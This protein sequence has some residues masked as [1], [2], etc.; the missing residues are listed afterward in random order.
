M[1]E[2]LLQRSSS[3]I[4]LV[5]WLKA[6]QSSLLGDLM[7]AQDS[8][9]ATGVMKRLGVLLGEMS[10]V[11]S[12]PSRIE[13]TSGHSFFRTISGRIT[14]R[15]GIDG[16]RDQLHSAFGDLLALSQALT[17][18]SVIEASRSVENSSLEVAKASRRWALYATIF[19][20]VA[21][22]AAI[23][24]LVVSLWLAPTDSSKPPANTI[25][26]SSSATSSSSPHS[27][28]SPK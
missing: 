7:E 10:F 14:E 15:L 21:A 26:P 22:V 9:A 25:S 13:E 19:T 24:Q 28:A 17:S 16:R 8:A 12:D 23:V 4:Y 5:Q 20:A 2:I 3:L 18:Q 27:S 6:T 1:A 11:V